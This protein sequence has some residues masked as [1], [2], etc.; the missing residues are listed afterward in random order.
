MRRKT[1]THAATAFHVW[2]L[3]DE[4]EPALD[5]RGS[6]DLV[7]Q[8]ISYLGTVN[9][10]LSGMNAQTNC[11]ADNAS[12]N[13]PNSILHTLSLEVDLEKFPANPQ[14][15]EGEKE[16]SNNCLLCSCREKENWIFKAAS[17]FWFAFI[18]LTIPAHNGFS[19]FKCLFSNRKQACW[20]EVLLCHQYACIS[21]LKAELLHAQLHD[22]VFFLARSKISSRWEILN[23]THT[24][25]SCVYALLPGKACFYYKS[26]LSLQDFI[27]THLPA[28]HPHPFFHPAEARRVSLSAN[29]KIKLQTPSSR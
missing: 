6:V 16:R 21:M 8:H 11:A 10:T 27:E 26:A 14:H 22:T 9:M 5:V 28:V 23:G 18:H 3:V 20:G 1:C 15:E 24:A 17:I 13:K 2:H 19:I 4:C 29:C 12:N 7:T 25:D